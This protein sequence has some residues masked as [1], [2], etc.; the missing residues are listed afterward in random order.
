MTLR[1]GSEVLVRPI[2]PSDK[3]A[4][5]AAFERLGANSRHMR[6][7]ASKGRLTGG[8]LAYFT[9][10]DHVDHEALI[11]TDTAGREIL[12]VARYVRLA[13]DREAA[14]IAVTVADDWQGCG[15]G[16]MLVMCLADRAREEGIH[17]FEAYALSDNVRII[18]L[19]KKIGAFSY[20]SRRGVSEVVVEL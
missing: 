7:L 20:R 15:L 16:T 18:R 11:A 5:R 2:G 10:V 19:L 14:E 6:F 9:E 4:L 1:D 8:E 17:R 13:S 12:A 3:P